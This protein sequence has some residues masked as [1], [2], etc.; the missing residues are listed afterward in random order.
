MSTLQARYNGAV[1]LC[2]DIVLIPWLIACVMG[3]LNAR[4]GCEN[5]KRVTE[6]CGYHHLLPEWRSVCGLCTVCDDLI[7]NGAEDTCPQSQRLLRMMQENYCNTKLSINI[8]CVSWAK[9][10]NLTF[11]L[12][13]NSVSI[14]SLD[15][16]HHLC[17]K[18]QRIHGGNSTKQ[19][20]TKTQKRSKE[21]SRHH[22]EQFAPINLYS[23]LWFPY[24]TC[25]LATTSGNLQ[26]KAK[27]AG[28]FVQN[29]HV[30]VELNH[31]LLF[32]L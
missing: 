9:A 22:K 6:A 32:L 30:L 25:L 7:F 19:W 21:P 14:P 8:S 26:Q 28:L 24:C 31:I 5:S 27:C 2:Y 12:K 11:I 15:S 3:G 29:S 18:D 13:Y 4:I 20:H 1:F 17:D 23:N 16:V 10:T